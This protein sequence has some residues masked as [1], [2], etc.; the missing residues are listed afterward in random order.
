MLG[1][2]D[3]YFTFVAGRSREVRDVYSDDDSDDDRLRNAKVDLSSDEE[4][5]LGS[6]RKS[7]GEDSGKKKKSARTIVESDEESE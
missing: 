5:P 7:K 2:R 6:K 1:K 4:G 3:L